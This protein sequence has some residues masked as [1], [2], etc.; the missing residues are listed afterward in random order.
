MNFKKFMHFQIVGIIFVLVLSLAQNISLAKKLKESNTLLARC[1]NKQDGFK[2]LVKS[3]T[4]ERYINNT[5]E[6]ELKNGFGK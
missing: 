4:I 2:E 1:I 5:I 6:K 3:E